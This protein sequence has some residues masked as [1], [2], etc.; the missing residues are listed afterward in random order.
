MNKTLIIEIP[1]GGLGDLL[2]HSHLP[3]IA[4]EHG[5]YQKVLINQTAVV[6]HAD[7]ARL[8]WEPNPFVDGYTEQPG[9]KINIAEAIQLTEA[10]Q[11][12]LDSIMLLFGLNDGKIRHEP[13]LFY[14]PK[15]ISDYHVKV[16]DPNFISWIGNIEKRD[17]MWHIKKHNIKLDA[18]MKF[19][20][21]KALFIAPTGMRMIETN[22][23]FDYCDLIHSAEVFYCLTSGSASIASA[24]GK[25]SIAFYGFPQ[26]KGLHHSKL[27]DYMLIE[28]CPRNKIS[29]FVKAPIKRL[30]SIIK[31]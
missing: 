9:I 16:Y 8:V 27:H 28:R 30:L 29:S 2:F 22:S 14:K 31:G 25:K 1:Y 19:R 15:F 7:Y 5:G 10:G 24:L 20:N 6:R 12:L 21:E 11:N 4:K 26:S 23:I 17:V 3:R 13:E 18:Y